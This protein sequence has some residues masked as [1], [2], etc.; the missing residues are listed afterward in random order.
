[1]RFLSIVI[2]IMLLVSSCTESG[3][4]Y[5]G[6]SVDY[7]V[8]QLHK[9]DEAKQLKAIEALNNFNPPA[10]WTEEYL[11]ELMQGSTSGLAPASSEVS[12]AA[13]GALQ[14][15]RAYDEEFPDSKLAILKDSIKKI[16]IDPDIK[17]TQDNRLEI[18]RKIDQARQLAWMGDSSKALTQLR[19]L[20]NSTGLHPSHRIAI[21]KRIE[22][23]S[24][25]KE[26]VSVNTK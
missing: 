21:E 7:W 12:R 10:P 8:K 1:M 14:R 9:Q 4:T 20:L 3:Q 25:S 17:N 24:A 6:K 13:E 16:T 18:D 2:L 11:I 15:F 22:S 26:G 5:K 23:I 19:D